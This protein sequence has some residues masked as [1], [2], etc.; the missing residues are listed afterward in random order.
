MSAVLSSLAAVALA[1]SC[2][3]I[4][5][6]LLGRLALGMTTGGRLMARLVEL[7]GSLPTLV[8]APV[9]DHWLGLPAPVTIGLVV[10][11]HQGLAVARCLRGAESVGEHERASVHD[12][13]SSSLQRLTARKAPLAAVLAL[14]VV[15]VVTLEAVLSMVELPPLTVSLGSL[16]AQALAPSLRVG[17]VM[18]LVCLF[19][20]FDQ[21]TEH[22]PRL[23]TRFR[24]KNQ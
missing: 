2:A 14:C 11:A 15:H 8:A 4:L 1:I 21:G 22:A 6:F 7:R 16:M 19:L 17:G 3:A 23:A 24:T 13:P 5:G 12:G 10:G 18:L 9:L 20:L